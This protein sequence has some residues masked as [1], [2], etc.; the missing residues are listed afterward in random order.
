MDIFGR[1]NLGLN[2]TVQTNPHG[3]PMSYSTATGEFTIH[4]GKTPLEP[5]P[6]FGFFYLLPWL[7]GYAG[8]GWEKVIL[9]ATDHIYSN[10]IERFGFYGDLTVIAMP[11]ID[12]TFLFYAIPFPREEPKPER[13][14]RPAPGF[15]GIARESTFST[16]VVPTTFLPMD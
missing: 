3:Y 7:A 9:V 2:Y 5:R 14:P 15:V 10:L 13:K 6:D 1:E 4:D 11:V 8:Q 12:A 16:P